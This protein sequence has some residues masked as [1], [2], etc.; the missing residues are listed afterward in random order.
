MSSSVVTHP[1]VPRGGVKRERQET[2]ITEDIDTK[3]AR[4]DSIETNEFWDYNPEPI[5]LNK[6]ITTPFMVESET[7]DELITTPFMVESETVDELITTPYAIGKATV[8]EIEG[9]SDSDGWESCGEEN[10]DRLKEVDGLDSQPNHL[11]DLIGVH[12]GNGYF[13]I[14]LPCGKDSLE[15]STCVRVNSS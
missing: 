3:C 2:D 14:T 8:N 5:D 15:P 12:E 11:S 4:T 13:L 6:L 1:T 7:V 9:D 10:C